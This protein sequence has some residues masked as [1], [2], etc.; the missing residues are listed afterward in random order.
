MNQRHK[1]IIIGL[2]H[3]P[4]SIKEV[5]KRASVTERT[6]RNDIRDINV[7]LEN[8]GASLVKNSKNEIE[9]NVLDSE[10]FEEFEK[11]YLFNFDFNFSEPKYR[12]IYIGLRFLFTENY[13]KLEDLMEEMYISRSTIKNDMKDVRDYLKEYSIDFVT[14]PHYGLRVVGNERDIRNAISTLINSVNEGLAGNKNHELSYLFDKEVLD[15]IYDILVQKINKSSIK[16]SDIALNNL[17]LHIAIAIKR[18]QIN[19]YFESSIDLDLESNKEYVLAKEIISTIERK[20][21]ITF[22][23][24]EITYITMHLM[25]TKLIVKQD[26]DVI[27]SQEEEELFEIARRIINTVGDK[28]Q[29]NLRDD[30]ELLTSIVMH[31]KPAIYRYH[32]NMNIRNPLL[33]SI[34]TN[35]SDVFDA[36]LLASEILVEKLGINFNED[37]LGYIAIHLGTAIERVKLEK[38]P[39]KTLVV[40]TTG[41]GSS[42]LLKYKLNSKFGE[43]LDIIDTTEMYNVENYLDKNLE[44]I[45]TTVPFNNKMNIPQIFISDIL[46][47]LNFEEIKDFIESKRKKPIKFLDLED[48]YINLEFNSKLEVLEYLTSQIVENHNEDKDLLSLILEREKIVTTALG[49]LV[50]IPHP[51]KPITKNTFLTIATL[52]QPID[53]DGKKV[54][55]VIILNVSKDAD[56]A[57]EEMYEILLE[58]ID[59]EENVNQILNSKN[60]YEVYKLFTKGR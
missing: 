39:L 27:L 60:E 51:I 55:L 49:N 14:K 29:Y 41:V 26:G 45:I 42:K 38:T 6:I 2:I 52:K 57:F 32:N 34:K 22:P 10:R 53:W 20:Y 35:Y 59:S 17:V 30:Q 18:I 54:Q 25:G 48:V 16:L 37:E 44:L 24:A 36:A 11:D 19:Q 56:V 7:N 9:I 46:G 58:T 43:F 4:M 1:E 5:S 13:L 28:L 21:D 47:D 3:N 23:N 50:A 40:C 8:Y 12:L 33:D 15:D 31:L